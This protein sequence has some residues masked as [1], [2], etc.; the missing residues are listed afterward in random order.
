MAL[1]LTPRVHL[2]VSSPS[3]VPLCMRRF[4]TRSVSTAVSLY[5]R[6]R[7]EGPSLHSIPTMVVHLTLHLAAD[8]AIRPAAGDLCARRISPPPH[9]ADLTSRSPDY[10]VRIPRRPAASGQVTD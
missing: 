6:E 1:T 4:M 7:G 8:R 5:G 10:L 2:F 3:T 9:V